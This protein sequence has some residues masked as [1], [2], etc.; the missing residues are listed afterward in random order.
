MF[1]KIDIL[2]NCLKNNGN[3]DFIKNNSLYLLFNFIVDEVNIN[4][5]RSPSY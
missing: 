5:S 1:R 3:K 4:H 2:N